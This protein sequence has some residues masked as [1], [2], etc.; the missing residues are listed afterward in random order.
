MGYK[1]K[2][3]DSMNLHAIPRTAGLK[4]SSTKYSTWAKKIF[5]L[6][7]KKSITKT[8][9]NDLMLKSKQFRVVAGRATSIRKQNTLPIELIVIENRTNC[10]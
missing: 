8:I 10:Q 7:E 5:Y 2:I 4:Q 1:I 6:K 3:V 9:Y